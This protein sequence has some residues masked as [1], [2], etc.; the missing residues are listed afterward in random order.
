M[1]SRGQRRPG[2][3]GGGRGGVRRGRR[4]A[5]GP[6][7]CT[8]ADAVHRGR[9]SA[10]GP[11]TRSMLA[12]L[13]LLAAADTTAPAPQLSLSLGGLT[14]ALDASLPRAAAFGFQGHVFP[15]A[16]ARAAD[17]APPLVGGTAASPPDAACTS[18]K[19]L[20]TARSWPIVFR[21][22]RKATRP[23]LLPV[24]LL[25]IQELRCLQHQLAWLLRVHQH[26]VPR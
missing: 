11:T 10:Q 2:A 3:P 21:P 5:Q 25:P 4:S 13:L 16:S 18:T 1:R 6:T 7:Q 20:S 24:Q 14:V 12:V 19:K 23:V 8:A 9:R 17:R 15:A 22:A 26:A